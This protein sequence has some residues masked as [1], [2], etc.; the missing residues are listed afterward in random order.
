[1]TRRNP[2]LQA[3]SDPTK[4]FLSFF[5]MT[6]LLIDL[7]SSG[8]S[9]LF[10]QNFAP[11]L[12]NYLNIQQESTFQLLTLGVLIGIALLLIYFTKLADWL[13]WILTK[14]GLTETI[15]PDT[16]KVIELTETCRGLVVI[17]SPKDDS[18]AEVAIRH[19]W[20]DSKASPQ[21]LEYC[22]IICTPDSIDY[23]RGLKK[24]LVD[25]G[26]EEHLHLYLGDSKVLDPMAPGKKLSLKIDRNDIHDPDHIMRLVNGIYAHAESLGIS[27]EE[28]IVDF[29]GGTKPLGVGAFL[30]CARPKRRLEYITLE[31]EAP[32]Q[33]PKILEIKVAYRLETLRERLSIRKFFK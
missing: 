29:T 4:N 25:E 26:I 18:P 9:E 32:R 11:W 6:V 24:K 31:G 5:L 20:N 16:A 30:A 10:W 8:I 33:R 27:E 14:V 2:I 15:V 28:I 12:Q 3:L 7:I 21:R 22:W 13:R 19:H 17:M 1:M 23:A